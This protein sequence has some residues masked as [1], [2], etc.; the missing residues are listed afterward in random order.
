MLSFREGT[1][2]W[3]DKVYVPLSMRDMILKQIHKTPSAGHWGEMKTLDLLTRTFDWPNSRLDVLK[4]CSLCT[5]CQ[6]IKV[7]RRP[8]Q[9]IMMPLPISD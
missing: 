9:G 3:K 5:S 4:F 7:D 6:S 2:W 8:R 1:W